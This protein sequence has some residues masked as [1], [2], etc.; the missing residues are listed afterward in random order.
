MK[1]QRISAVVFLL[2]SN[3]IA[4]GLWWYF[5]DFYEYETPDAFYL[6]LLLP[7]ISG[8]YLWRIDKWQSGVVLSSSKFLPN[9]TGHW[10]GRL[11][12]VSIFLELIALAL[13][14]I[15]IARPQSKS[16][17]ENISKEGI[18]IV[19][20]MD[21]SG[22]MLAKD[23]EPNRLESAKRVAQEFVDYRP[24]DRIGLVV[25]EG[26]SYTQTPVTTDHIVVK[27]AIEQMESGKVEGGTAIGM[28]L[29]TAVNRL[30]DTEAK[31]KVIVLLTD[32]V[33]N[34][35]QIKP[36]DA[37][38]IAKTFDIKVH[39]IGVGSRGNALTPV[40][41]KPNGEYI[42]DY[43]EVEIDEET[44]TK[45][46]EKTGGKYF[47]ATSPEELQKI[48]AEIDKLEKT[49]FEVTEFSR[50]TEEFLDF[51][52]AAAGCLLLAFLLKNVLFRNI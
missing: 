4:L 34:R 16:S 6:L 8:I 11:R 41:V 50:R 33:N 45:A 24:D 39:T 14:V 23:F 28:G 48:Y 20:S 21:V 12:H 26:E 19:I 35:G 17:Y 49:E 5:R 10:L 32:G 44:L 47:R 25:F 9:E 22:S 40:G 1:D 3:L 29:A 37:A 36:L 43:R 27:N 31:S 18:D 42:F 52:I 2:L 15:S 51:G 13:L 30:K 46:A 7:V 38:R